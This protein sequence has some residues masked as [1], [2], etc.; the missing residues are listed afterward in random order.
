MMG[1][2]TYHFWTSAFEIPRKLALCDV[3][4]VMYRKSRNHMP[5]TDILIRQDSISQRSEITIYNM[6]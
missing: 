2:M 1:W 5:L 6:I 4:V 3:L